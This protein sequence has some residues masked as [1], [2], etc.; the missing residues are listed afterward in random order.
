[1]VGPVSKLI[2]S[3]LGE[4][5][6]STGVEEDLGGRVTVPDIGLLDR[7]VPFGTTRLLAEASYTKIGVTGSSASCLALVGLS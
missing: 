2:A 5:R 4:T 1:M 3:G 7:I 6:G